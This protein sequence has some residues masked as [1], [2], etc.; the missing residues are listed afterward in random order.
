VTISWQAPTQRMDGAALTSTDLASFD[1]L[2]FDDATGTMRT[3]RI[4]DPT[5][6][7]MRVTNLQTNTMYHFSVT[8][9]DTK[10]YTSAASQAVD[11]QL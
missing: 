10:G 6:R 9:T 4:T 7:S 5:S 11:L 3:T 8:A 2:Y 1:V